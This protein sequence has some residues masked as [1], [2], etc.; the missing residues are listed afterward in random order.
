MD[1]C[2]AST[3]ETCVL[4]DPTQCIAAYE[5]YPTRG[6]YVCSSGVGLVVF[7]VG[8][9]GTPG[10][11]ELFIN[12]D[13]PGTVEFLIAPKETHDIID[14]GAH[15]SGMAEF[16]KVVG[17]G[18]LVL[19]TTYLAAVRILDGVSCGPW[20]LHE[21]ELPTVTQDVVIY[22]AVPVL[23]GENLILY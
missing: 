22:G 14:F 3:I 5:P 23:S 1:Q 9:S 13:A 12:L 16:T 19:S 7:D 8:P 15:T 6:R 2:N 10:C 11:V 18:N 4:G 20:H 21:F 17:R